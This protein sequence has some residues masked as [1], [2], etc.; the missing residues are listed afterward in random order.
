MNTS[1]VVSALC[2]AL[3]GQG[4]Q[5]A[6]PLDVL[7]VPAVQSQQA[8]HGVLLGIGR[9]GTRLVAVG[10]RGIILLS[11]NNGV[12]WRQA[13]VAVSTSLTAVQFV[14]AQRG[15]AVGH[16]GVVLF[17]G[18]AGE[19]WQLQLDG[20]RAAALELAAAQLAGDDARLTA[21]RRLVADGADKPLLALSFSDARHGLVVGA[22]G[23]A[24]ATEDGGAT[25]A[26]WA[27]RLPNPQGL[28]LYAVARDG[29]EVVVAGEQGLVLRS[30]DNGAHFDA[31][32]SPYDG[33]YFS[34]VRLPSGDLL[35]GGLRGHLFSLRDGAFKEVGNPVPVSINA[36]LVSG[37]RLLVVNQA[38]GVLQ[39]HLDGSGLTP[40]P[41][42]AAA[43]LSALA[44]GADGSL[45]GV[46][47]AG[48]LR[49]SSAPTQA[50]AE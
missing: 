13:A 4:A 38:G 47:F 42:A 2:L 22:Y 49:L 36:A 46:G 7:T 37:Q 32:A 11:D 27:G 40:L 50:L 6:E 20:R 5:A 35:L 34:L 8:L 26:S 25:W 29:G 39:G 24:L 19:H 31:L 41:L 15:W 16:G 3:A 48:P 14:D 9:A 33:S 44:E 1:L 10:E 30:T 23:L 43:P 21:A 45:I 28:H 18:D 12:S 17:S